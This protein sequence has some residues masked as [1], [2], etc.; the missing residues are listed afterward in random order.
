MSNQH[1]S[2]LRFL[3]RQDGDISRQPVDHEMCVHVFGGTSSPSCINYTLKRTAVDGEAK[4]GKEA[5]ETLQNN[6]Y[7][8][9]LLKSADDENKAIKLIQEVK[10]ICV[11]GGFRL[12]K[13]LCNSKNV[14]QS[15]PEDHRREGV[16][17]K[18]Q[19]FGW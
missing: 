5:A 1:R 7:V 14:L 18:E 9:D 2:F 3:W 16:K 11:S 12:T 8:D 13:C 10:A 15:I 19:R 17:D 6:F 4:F